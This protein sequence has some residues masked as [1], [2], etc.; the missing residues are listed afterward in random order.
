VRR[1]G[2]ALAAAALGL[3]L[4]A[5][6]AAREVG[7]DPGVLPDGPGRDEVFHLCTG[8][9]SSRVV[10][11]QALSRGRW[12]ETLTWMSERHGMPELAGAQRELFLDYLT[13]H[14][15]PGAEGEAKGS[16]FLVRPARPNPFAP[17]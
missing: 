4:A 16:P 13:A 11:N 9:H 15:G 10:R 8:C 1:R 12:D 17:R 2:R 14:F 7:E 3:G 5:A 6:A